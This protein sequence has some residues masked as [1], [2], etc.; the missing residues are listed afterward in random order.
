MIY[1]KGNIVS[2]PKM[3]WG[4]GVVME[5]SDGKTV[6]I[7]F[8]KV[9][10]KKLS[11]QY[12]EP[13]LIDVTTLP[14]IEIKKLEINH[15]IYEGVH[16]VDIYTDI[17]SMYPDH[18]VIIE[19]GCYFEI[20]ED[21]ALYLS[22]LYGWTVYERQHGVLMTGFPDNAKHIWNDLVSFKKPYLIVSQLE[23][24]DNGNIKRKITD[25]YPK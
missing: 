23:N 13:I 6:E 9:G 15:K 22:Q 25:I 18:L 4:R 20:I 10:I 7:L 14:T 16:F 21:D 17:K 24:M 5:N 3:D 8:E 11:L 12:V 19:N 2:H 1:K